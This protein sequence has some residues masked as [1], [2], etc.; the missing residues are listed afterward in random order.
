M[1]WLFSKNKSIYLEIFIYSFIQKTSKKQIN[2]Y[3]GLLTTNE[4]NDVF[5]DFYRKL[6]Y[7]SVFE[8]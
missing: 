3:L 8:M 1:T 6:N 4:R 5:R 7:N 2:I